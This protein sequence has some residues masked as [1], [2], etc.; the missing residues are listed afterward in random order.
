MNE[1]V[2]REL[3]KWI[4]EIDEA[5]ISDYDKTVINIILTHYDELIEAGGT[6]AGKRS[7]KF[8][9]F[10]NEKN[11]KADTRIFKPNVSTS[12]SRMKIKRI[13]GL[14][15]ESFRGF[16]MNRHF[17]LDKQYVLLYGPNGSGKTSFS[18]A[19]EYV[20]L[21][22]IEEADANKIKL[23]TYITNTQTK[24]GQ[25][26]IINCVYED[27]SEGN[28]KSD[29]ESYRFAFI[30][31]NRISDFSHLSALNSKNQN[32]RIAALFG[33]SIFNEF[34]QGFSSSIFEKYLPIES[35]TEKEFSSQKIVRD[36]NEKELNVLEEELKKIDIQVS[37][38]LKKIGND[39]IK[40]LKEAISYLNDAETGILTKK[41][42]A[43]ENG[44]KELILEQDVDD[45][46]HKL[47]EIRNLFNKLKELRN[48]LTDY[49]LQINLKKLYNAISELEEKDYCPACGTP[50]NETRYNP[51]A[52]AKKELKHMVEVDSLQKNIINVSKQIYNAIKGFIV[53][54]K[55]HIKI[56]EIM[57]IDKSQLL[58]VEMD[59]I[60][61]YDDC[62]FKWDEL[63]QRKFDLERIKETI[64]KYNEKAKKENDLYDGEIRNI[65]E[66]SN[67]LVALDA[68]LTDKQEKKKQYYESIKK[69]DAESAATQAKIKEE[70]ETGKY[71]KEIGA[72]Y[73]RV[74][75][76]LST[77]CANLPIKIAQDLEEKII[78]YYNTINQDDAEFEKISNIT[79][80]GIGANGLLIT[81][82][83][84]KKSDALQVLS[85]GHIKILGLSILLAKAIKD[86]LDFI[87]FDDI[88]NAIDDDHR[89]GVANLIIRH[90]DFVEKQI[91]LSTHGDQF[92][93]KLRDK[94]G[95]SASSKNSIIYKFIPADSLEERGVVVEFSDAKTPLETAEKKFY[96]NELKAS[97]SSA[98]QAMECLAY[99]IW[100][101][102]AETKDGMLKVGM[103]NP[104]SLPELSSI[105]DA[106]VKKTSKIEGMEEITQELQTLKEESNW[107]IFNKGTHYEDEQKEFERADI[108]EVL[109]HL[110]LLDDLV[111]NIK[112]IS[113]AVEKK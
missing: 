54:A 73:V 60:K 23:Q 29:Y 46:I 74:V 28:A 34:V 66:L 71:N 104:K 21:N 70:K 101:I 50:L 78:E 3:L 20:L 57:Q 19:L 14:D 61:R 44:Y 112:I 38:K 6:A 109:K 8:A 15:V 72:A 102:I 99:N 30:E 4:D 45:I 51:Y 25:K 96:E 107:R 47:D 26:P 24:K 31:K 2:G 42:R 5:K 27:G 82:K 86:G 53:F 90:K 1:I 94:I 110:Q 62:V 98:R 55:K 37:E 16:A 9:E 81:F 106:L 113:E 59:E 67:S 87:I 33:L 84:G 79:L 32:E 49:A 105:V 75:S 56:C 69:F 91:I 83:D 39:E 43:R 100:N 103:R 41:Q 76:N 10:V 85:E 68:K 13:K 65:T 95:R 40:S 58:E 111:S 7:I 88:V 36:I 108:K 64:R 48:G 12:A 35:E 80:P 11:R 63:S 22:S 93:Y 52:T 18:E 77:Y 17:D 97:A 89:N 92:I